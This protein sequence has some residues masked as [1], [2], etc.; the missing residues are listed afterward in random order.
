MKPRSKS[1]PCRRWTST[2]L[3]SNN[4][5]Q[6]DERDIRVRAIKLYEYLSSIT[7]TNKSAFTYPECLVIGDLALDTYLPI[8]SK[9]SS[10]FCKWS[11]GHCY[12]KLVGVF[13]NDNMKRAEKP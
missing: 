2:R 5:L 6:P 12:R 9:L 11:V 1:D 13:F 3:P 4:H 8:Q 7:T 10:E